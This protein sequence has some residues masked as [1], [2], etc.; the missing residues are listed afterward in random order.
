MQRLDLTLPTA[1]ENVALDEALL[2]A[3]ESRP[4]PTE[5]LRI[6]EPAAPLVVVGRASSIGREVRLEACRRDDVPVLRRPSGGTAIVAAPGCLLYAVVLSTQL[7][8][9]LSAID[10][11]H[12][13]VLGALAA[14][15]HRHVAG[16]EHRGISDLAVVDHKFSG[17]ALRCRRTHLLYHGTLL[18]DMPLE[19]IPRYLRPPPRQPEY[20]QDREH[21]DF[22]RN[23]DISRDALVDAVAAAFGDPPPAADWPCEQTAELIRTR[24]GCDAWNHQIA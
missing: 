12:C 15:L 23:L 16:V 24:Y 3:A 19:I 4:E 5:W 8:P 7:R 22:V 6:W 2:L 20:R 13:F 14:A 9:A 10:A 17:N 11:A 1:A 18:F 21:A